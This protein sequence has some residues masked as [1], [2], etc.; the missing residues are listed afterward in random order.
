MCVCVINIIFSSLVQ[1]L[2]CLTVSRAP[3]NSNLGI[4][5]PFR[6][7]NTQNY[8]LVLLSSMKQHHIHTQ[9]NLKINEFEFF[10]TVKPVELKHLGTLNLL[11]S[12]KSASHRRHCSSCGKWF[13]SALLQSTQLLKYPSSMQ[14]EWADIS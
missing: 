2:F 9:R 11:I 12:G 13:I 6:G 3:A 8:L 10:F 7:A 4:V 1:I 14:Y 5:E